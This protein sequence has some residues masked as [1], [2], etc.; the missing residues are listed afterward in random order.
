[1]FWTQASKI[2]VGRSD[3]TCSHRTCMDMLSAAI[4]HG[5]KAGTTT[6]NIE[7]PSRQ[8]KTVKYD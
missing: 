2:E 1:M 4:Q 8:E 7:D 6:F 5:R 3:T